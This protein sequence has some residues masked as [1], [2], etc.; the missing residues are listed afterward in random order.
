MFWDNYRWIAYYAST[1][2]KQTAFFLVNWNAVV[3]F[4]YWIPMA[5]QSDFWN[6]PIPLNSLFIFKLWL[7]C[8]DYNINIC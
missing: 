5:Y 4:I 2:I 3:F 8:F 1:T 7:Y 6:S